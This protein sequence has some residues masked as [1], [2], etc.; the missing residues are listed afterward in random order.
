MINN[1][2][3][4]SNWLNVQM[5][6]GNKPY[7]NTTQPVAGL[8]RY[9]SNSNGGCIEVYDGTSWQQMGN[10]SANIDLNEHAKEILA[11][12]EKKMHEERK[13][14]EM[15]DRHPGL[16]ELHNKFEMMRVL[17]MEEEKSQ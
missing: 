1:I 5:Y 8:I 12:A 10:G 16:K 3:G 13:L 4:N 6:P 2:Y 15:M 9:N 7:V 11:W 17:C 14:K